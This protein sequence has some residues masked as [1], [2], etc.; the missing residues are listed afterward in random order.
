MVAPMQSK[1]ELDHEESGVIA[2]SGPS[3]DRDGRPEMV[4][5]TCAKQPQL[6]ADLSE[7]FTR[8]KHGRGSLNWA[9]ARFESQ[10]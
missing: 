2:E 3:R 9:L 4:F 1:M 5:D 6:V 8:R 7:I 10:S